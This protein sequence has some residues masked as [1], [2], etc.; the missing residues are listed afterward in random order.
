MA[1]ALVWITFEY[2][3]PSTPLKIPLVISAVL[4]LGWIAAPRK[5]WST[6]VK[7]ILLFLGVMVI[8]IPI[9]VNTYSAVWTTYGMVVLLGFVVTPL[10]HFLDSLW[11]LRCFFHTLIAVFLYVGIW[12]ILH[13]G[14]GPAGS[15]GGQD[16]NYVAAA[17][18]IGFP[19]AYFSVFLAR[20]VWMR[21]AFAMA[22]GVML[23]A[24]VVTLS[25]GGAIAMGAVLIYCWLRSRKRWIGVTLVGLLVAAMAVVPDDFTG[26][27]ERSPGVAAPS[28][29]SR[30][31]G[32]V[33]TVTDTTEST[34][35]MR[36][37]LWKI[38]FRMFLANPLS[39]VGP[40]NFVWNI[41][42]YQSEEQFAKYG[43]TLASFT[44]SL[45]FELMAELGLAGCAL[46]LVIA[47]SNFRDVRMVARLRKPDE[48]HRFSEPDASAVAYYG[49]A[50]TASLIAVH[51]SAAFLPFLYQSYFWV[52][53]AMA[54][55]LR[56]IVVPQVETSA[57]RMKVMRAGSR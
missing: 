1:M 42:A 33:E 31:W 9:S 44:H 39:G 50:I 19:V 55:A 51:V 46:F 40:G 53:S 22:A 18:S 43:R 35:E 34:A 47:Y 25:R 5:R 28:L 15:G 36:L 23:L 26:D 56:Q 41:G 57:P 27:G 7:C 3:R 21:V 38:A 20:S 13:G 29:L 30:Y 8:D 12:A 49:H 14:Y 24:S 45:Y 11:K 37:E 17:M 48:I 54:I 2:A 16:E 4:T 32:E 6:Q 10:L 52:V